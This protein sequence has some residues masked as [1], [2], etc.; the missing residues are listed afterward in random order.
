MEEVWKSIQEY[1]NYE[2]SNTGLVKNIKTNKLLKL[3]NTGGYQRIS[4]KNNIKRNSLNIHRLVALAF[5]DNPLNK[6][7]VN[8]KDKNKLNNNV[9]NLE[10][11]TRQENNIH[12]W[13]TS[14]YRSNN[15]NKKIYRIDIS[16]GK[17]L[18]MYNSIQD[19]AKWV[20]D[21]K[22]SSNEHN[23]RNSIGNVITGLSSTSYG[24]KWRHI[25][26]I[27]NL[28]GEIWK[29]INTTLVGE[30]NCFVSNL[31]RFKRGNI[32]T[33]NS[34]PNNSGYILVSINK[35]SYLIHR[36]VALTFIEN[37]ENKEQVNHID[38]NKL[39][40]Q[41]DNLEWVTN[42]ENQLHKH[43][44]GLGNNFTRRIVQ[45]DLNENKIQEFESIVLASKILG[46]GKSNIRGVL[47]NYRKTA[48]GFIFKYAD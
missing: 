30:N 7:D 11:V 21:N 19:A 39:N 27:E 4:L 31:G 42:K 36:L 34:K 32:V 3:N 17:E 18:E 14:E 45:Y 26:E 9:N 47:V 12:R 1:P 20:V 33:T 10:W 44:I 25:V 15:R 24:F 22:L 2:V 5:I 41:L 8:H 38:G 29:E 16:D 48:G 28:D 13:S 35:K 6:P 23:A 46:I 43:K 37:P 40:N